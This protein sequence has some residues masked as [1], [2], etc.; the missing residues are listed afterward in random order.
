MA[1]PGNPNEM[2]LPG[3]LT[4][5][6]LIL[7]TQGQEAADE[8]FTQKVNL[9]VQQE[10]ASRALKQ[11]EEIERQ[12]LQG[13]KTPDFSTI[14]LTD[15]EQQRYED[16]SA[17]IPLEGTERVLPGMQPGLQQIPMEE[18]IELRRESIPSSDEI[19]TQAEDV[20]SSIATQ[21]IQMGFPSRQN[22]E[23]QI[24]EQLKIQ[25]NQNNP[26][27]ELEIG[28]LFE[29]E[30]AIIEY[31]LRNLAKAEAAKYETAED[32]AQ[33]KI[34]GQ[35]GVDRARQAGSPYESLPSPVKQGSRIAIEPE[36]AAT[37]DFTWVV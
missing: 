27:R 35:F 34:E 9:Y 29:H 18:V 31:D 28:K 36:K 2:L 20:A 21:Q 7:E 17:G 13:N 1:T 3:D 16:F 30:I 5:Y 4:S 33:E 14:T 15:E 8:F 12:K 11:Q 22:L 19:Q 26:G 24:F 25:Y 23:D 37:Q 32:F 6:Q 10:Q